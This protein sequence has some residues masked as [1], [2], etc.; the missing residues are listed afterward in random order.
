MYKINAIQSMRKLF[1]IRCNNLKEISVTA[2]LF[3]IIRMIVN[4]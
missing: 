2:I 3:N 1:V 4:Y